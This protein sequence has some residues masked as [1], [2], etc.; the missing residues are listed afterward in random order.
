[1]SEWLMLA[2]VIAICGVLAGLL[3]WSGSGDDG[4]A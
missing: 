4:A 3:L 1:M 2:I